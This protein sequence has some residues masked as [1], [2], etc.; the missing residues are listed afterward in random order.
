MPTP[1][2]GK[3]FT[4][5]Q[6]FKKFVFKDRVQDRK[7]Q[8]R[9]VLGWSF[10]RGAEIWHRQTQSSAKSDSKKSKKKKSSKS[11]SADSDFV[12]TLLLYSAGRKILISELDLI[13]DDDHTDAN[14]LRVKD[15]ARHDA[16]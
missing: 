1:S 6:T 4:F 3:T 11:D 2:D 15:K 5:T 9:Q 12:D 13:D 10:P 8:E 16:L 7:A 14:K